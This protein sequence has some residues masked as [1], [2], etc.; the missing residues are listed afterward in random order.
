MSVSDQYPK[1]KELPQDYESLVVYLGSLDFSEG[2]V[3]LSG[4]GGVVRIEDGES[5]FTISM[6]HQSP[7]SLEVDVGDYYNQI[8]VKKPNFVEPFMNPIIMQKAQKIATEELPLSVE[9][10]FN[11]NGEIIIYKSGF[12]AIWALRNYNINA[13]NMVQIAQQW[14]NTRESQL[15]SEQA[16]TLFSDTELTKAKKREWKKALSN[17]TKGEVD[18]GRLATLRIF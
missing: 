5:S 8:L 14:L 6:H 11:D 7:Q 10:A 9:G 3:A 12:G 18:L 15:S 4:N 16:G 2:I 17:S 13:N 1:N